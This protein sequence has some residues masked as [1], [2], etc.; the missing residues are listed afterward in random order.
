[1][2]RTAGRNL[3]LERQD[4]VA[5]QVLKFSMQQNER[6]R[7]LLE[8]LKKKSTALLGIDISSSSIKLLELSKQGS[9]YRVE[10]YASRHLP[11]GAVVEKNISKLEAVGEEL[12]KMASLL[13]TNSTQAAVAVSGSAVITKTI[14]LNASLSDS[15]M[16]NQITVEADQ[17]IPY[18]LDE[19]AID[20]ERQ[21]PSRK[22]EGMVEVL[23]AACK[24]ENVDMRVDALQIGGF[25]AKVVDIEAYAMERAF[26]LL[27][28]Q[29][30]L[31]SKGL[32]AIMDIGAT[33]TTMYIL[34]NGASIYMR[35]QVFG[36]AR[37][38]SSI[39]SRYGLSPAEAEA[40]IVSGEL[41]DSFEAEVLQPFR[42]E[43]VE[44]VSRSLQFFF[45]SSQ[46]ND[47]DM[48][49]LAGGAASTKGLAPTMQEALS[50]RTVVANPFAKMTLSSK[51]NKGQLKND[52][53]SLLMACGLAMR[54][55]NDG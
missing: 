29:M 55:F 22:N 43:M 20:F 40:A 46:Y 30:D 32:V 17:Y 4:F 2:N 11:E 41:P 10:N 24:K 33:M 23:L 25:E 19:V 53:A 16:E 28:D 52:A 5:I 47:V 12:F 36:G 39:Q 48:I 51:V 14:E 8:F 34:R 18:P 37:L 49:L 6:R 27:C 21:G 26:K 38:S 31:D 9:K 50:T 42:E 13:K 1:V 15:E 35:E 45:S 54:G 44:Q 3:R 7:V